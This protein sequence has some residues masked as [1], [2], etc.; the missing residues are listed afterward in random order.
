MGDDSV[1]QYQI[2]A[3]CCHVDSHVV[4]DGHYVTYATADDVTW[5]KFDDVTVT[6]V[7]VDEE[8]MS[9]LVQQNVYLIIYRHVT[10]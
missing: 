5:Y 8:L 6:K 7:N 1:T 3:M 10:S 2:R 4:S 9:E